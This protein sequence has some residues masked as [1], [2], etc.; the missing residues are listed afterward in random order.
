[1]TCCP[2]P[3]PPRLLPLHCRAGHLCT[4]AQYPDVNHGTVDGKPIRE[5][6]ADDAW[7]NG[8]FITTVQQRGAAIIKVRGHRGGARA[9]C[10]LSVGGYSW[11]GR[12]SECVS[13]RGEGQG[14]HVAGAV[15]R[16]PRRPPDRS[17]LQRRAARTTHCIPG[18]IGFHDVKTAA[19]ATLLVPLVPRPQAKGNAPSES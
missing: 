14:M 15:R 19:S 4:A 13:A 10:L 16:C 11:R 2:D 6:V 7:L 3:L 1:M 17:P 5:A 9:M 18:Y 12:H 8:E